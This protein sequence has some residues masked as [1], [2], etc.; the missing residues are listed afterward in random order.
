MDHVVADL[1][2]AAR[3]LRRTPGFTATAILT[4]AL[5]IGMTTAVFTVVDGSM[6]RPFPYPDFDRI[7]LVSEATQD[8]RGMSVSWPNF[9]DW[10]SQASEVFQELGVYRGSIATLSG[11][12]APERL[13]G[14]VVSSSVFAT[15]GITPRLGRTFDAGDDG[16]GARRVV[17]ISE[18]LWRSHFG[19]A[20]DVVGRSITLNNQTFQ[21]AGVMP[22]SLRFPS[23]LTDLW[24]PLGLAVNG[25]PK[26]RDNHP[27]LTAFGRLK[28]AVSLERARTVMDAVAGRLSLQYPDTNHGSRIVV[29]PYYESIVASV[30]PAFRILLG[31]VGLVL[32]IACANL[33]NL[34]L[35]RAEARQRE[36]GIR[37]ALGASRMRLARQ[38]VT[39]ALLVSTVG[40]ALG[41]LLANWAVRAF[42][43]FRPTSIPRVDLIQVDARV[44]MFA[45]AVSMLSGLLFGAAPALRR[46]LANAQDALR[47]GRDGGAVGTGRIRSV[48]VAAEV[49]IAL[50]LLVGAGLL[51]RSLNRLMSVDLGFTPTRVVS[52]QVSLPTASYPTVEAWTAFHQ[53]LLDRVA[54]APGIEAVGL[55]SNLPFSG[56][57]MESTLIKE[58]DP[59]PAANHPGEECVFQTGS[60]DYFRTVG[61]TM[62]RGR[63][64][65][66]K[67]TPSSTRVAIVDDALVARLFGDR[68]PIGQRIAFEFEGDS[69]SDPRPMYREIVGVVHHVKSYGLTGEPPYVQVFTPFTQLP[70]WMKDR[71]PGMSL[72]VR[73]TGDATTAVATVRQAIRETDPRV[74]VFGVQPLSDAIGLALE[75]PRINLAL[76]ASFAGLALILSVIG[77]Y[78]VLSYA[79]SQRTR[80]IGVRVALGAERSQIARLVMRQAAR[81]V[82]AGLLVGLVGAIALSTLLR[83]LLFEISPTD[84]WTFAAVAALLAITAGVATALPARRAMR[85]DPI[86]ALRTE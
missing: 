38:L 39:E 28:P 67:D 25:F 19:E 10:Q 24:M 8:G 58:G 62:V 27:G 22:A 71:R 50:I 83:S 54:H 64:F 1:R 60:T 51:A 79:V 4:L 23:R 52:M 55:T 37:A 18:R 61:M 75:E 17:L 76:F 80:E 70:F 73:T 9:L 21:I 59:I 33:A 81:V 26:A 31:A 47:R 13:S 32:L 6:L 35:V 49:A 72:A 68:D 20:S 12:D 45:V 69:P 40:G 2:Y 86:V 41:V 66:E 85:V 15:V 57:A 84:P 44:L 48:L 56:N 3:R 36:L 42:V 11:P 46:S 65:S 16:P 77:V 78:G 29:T 14:A 7:M 82:S 53:S 30:R 63:T 74:P 34:M 5:G 43:A